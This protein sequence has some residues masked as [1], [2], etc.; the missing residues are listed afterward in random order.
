[1]PTWETRQ[2]GSKAAE[3]GSRQVP[4]VQEMNVVSR[5]IVTHMA[6]R[7][8]VSWIVSFVVPAFNRD[9][10]WRLPLNE[11]KMPSE[12]RNLHLLSIYTYSGPAA[13]VGSF[14]FGP[15]AKLPA[16]IEEGALQAFSLAIMTQD[17]RAEP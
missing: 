15:G 10:T 2:Q 16:D 11:M 12:P 9:N 3:D 4:S 6:G 1:M 17:A 13:P 14:H 8:L 7:P 5:G